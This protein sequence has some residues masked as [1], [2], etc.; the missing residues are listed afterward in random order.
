M[1]LLNSSSSSESPGMLCASVA[2]A[3]RSIS[4]QRSEQNGR[5]GLC[6]PHSTGELQVGQ[7]TRVVL[8]MLGLCAGSDKNDV[9][10]QLQPAASLYRD[11]LAVHR[12][13]GAN[14]RRGWPVR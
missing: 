2:Q 14:V 9:G 3:P 13:R 6:G 1:S 12:R 4:L 10:A 8:L 7:V 5:L 11:R